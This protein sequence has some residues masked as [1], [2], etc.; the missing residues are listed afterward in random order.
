ME[1]VEGGSIESATGLAEI[2]KL[3]GGNP[4]PSIEGD[5][6]VNSPKIE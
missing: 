3:N 2:L 5:T 1:E 6:F 4:H